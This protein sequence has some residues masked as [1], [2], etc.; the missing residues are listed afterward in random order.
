VHDRLNPDTGGAYVV[1]SFHH[2][3]FLTK[4]FGEC[5]GTDW[6]VT[7]SVVERRVEDLAVAVADGSSADADPEQARQDVSGEN[8]PVVGL[9]ATAPAASA[10]SPEGTF[11]PDIAYGKTVTV[12]LCRRRPRDHAGDGSVAASGLDRDA[13][14]RHVHR[15]TDDWYRSMN[16]MLTSRRREALRDKFDGIGSADDGGERQQQQCNRTVS[17]EEGYGM[18]FT[19]EEREH[20][21]FDLFLEDWNAFVV[22]GSDCR[23]VEGGGRGQQH[24]RHALP[25]ADSMSFETAVKFLE[26]MQ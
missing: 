26:E 14:Q 20:L 24:N 16:P 4:L 13:V 23:A 18:L 6:T 11:E 19:E 5:P 25:M 22:E 9:E 3:D 8:G 12:V 7:H 17:L 1:V 10:W 15:C 2:P 21:T